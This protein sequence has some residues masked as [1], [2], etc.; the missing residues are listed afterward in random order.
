MLEAARWLVD[1]TLAQPQF[2][3]IG[4]VCDVENDASAR[5]LERIPMIKEG[6]L[7]RWLVHPAFGDVP[8]DCF[9]F[10]RLKGA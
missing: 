3:R 2:H 6:I 5:L 10:S 4:A 7:R 1:W 9:V 8:R